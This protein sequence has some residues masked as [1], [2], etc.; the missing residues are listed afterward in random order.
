MDYISLAKGMIYHPQKGRG[1]AHIMHLCMHTV[2]L[3]KFC[4]GM[5]LTEIN[6]FDGRTLFLTPL[7]I[8]ASDAIH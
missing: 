2:D 4:H 8:D 7:T 1:W 6:K 3:E 5:P